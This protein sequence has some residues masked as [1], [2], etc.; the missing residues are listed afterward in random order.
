LKIKPG[1]TVELKP[2]SF[3]LMLMDLK[4]PI[5][6]GKPFKATLMFAKAGP[7]DVEFAVEQI[8]ANSRLREHTTRTTI[9]GGEFSLQAFQGSVGASPIRSQTEDSSD[10]PRCQDICPVFRGADGARHEGDHAVFDDHD[11]R[12][13]VRLPG[14]C[15]SSD[16]NAKSIHVALSRSWLLRKMPVASVPFGR[17]HCETL[18]QIIIET[19]A[20]GCRPKHRRIPNM[21]GGQ[22]LVCCADPLP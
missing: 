17:A 10:W 20:R 9:K 8:G 15:G 18:A 11:H 22:R 5:Q 13:A 21:N 1:Q 12:H 3:H 7:V 6:Q 2:T 19:F 4:G 14:R 16:R